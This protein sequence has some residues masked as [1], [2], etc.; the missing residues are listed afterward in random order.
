M[1][2]WGLINCNPCDTPIGG[3][4]VRRESEQLMNAVEAT[5]FRRAAARVNYLSQD[6]PDL[7]VASRLLAMRMAQPRKGDEGILKRVLRYL[8][9]HPRSV[10][11]YYWGGDASNLELYIPIVTWVGIWNK[12]RSTSG[13]LVFY[14][15][16]LVG[17]WSKLQ[18]NPAPS[19]G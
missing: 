15:G 16:H 7:N 4:D 2:D 1:K 12:R 5:L 13:G 8:K 11:S 14:G 6:R 3:E 10:Y 9:G 18:N 17:H 19:S